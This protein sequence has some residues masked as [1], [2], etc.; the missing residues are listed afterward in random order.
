VCAYSV[1]SAT[2]GGTIPDPESGLVWVEAWDPSYNLPYY[3]KFDTGDSQWEWPTDPGAH[4]V[5]YGSED[6][7]WYWKWLNQT[8]DD[9]DSVI[10]KKY[11]EKN[12]FGSCFS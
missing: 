12:L 3:V 1:F 6:Y 5:Q 4:V 11:S 10:E 9:G 2:I 7:N 8:V